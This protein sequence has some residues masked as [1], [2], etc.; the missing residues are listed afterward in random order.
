PHP[1]PPTGFP[2]RPGAQPAGRAPRLRGALPEPPRP[3]LPSPGSAAPATAHLP[4]GSVGPGWARMA[5]GE[6]QSPR[7]KRCPAAIAP[8]VGAAVLHSFPGEPGP[9]AAGGPGTALGVPGLA[10]GGTR[11]AQPCPAQHLWSA[12]RP[13]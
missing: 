4:L 11:P 9:A 12:A 13:G 3:E 6:A 8:A 2:A 1:C 10:K 7:G 5:A